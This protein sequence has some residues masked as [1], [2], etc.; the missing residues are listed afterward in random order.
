[1]D[2]KTIFG[3]SLQQLA[4]IVG[5]CSTCVGLTVHVEGRYAKIKEIDE[6]FQKN[7]QQLKL[8]HFLALELLSEL[9]LE[10]RQEIRNKLELSLNK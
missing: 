10:K 6:K 4:I 5:F 3:L 1:M 8:A 2:D 7:D 9:P